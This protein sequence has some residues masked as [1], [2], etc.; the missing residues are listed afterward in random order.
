M[1]Y[2]AFDPPSPTR[3]EGPRRS[4]PLHKLRERIRIIRMPARQR[5]T[6]LHDIAGSPQHAPF[7]ELPRHVIVRAENVEIAGVDARDHEVDGLL[8]R[9]GAGRL[10][11]AA[12]RGQRGEDV[13][14]DHQMR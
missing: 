8:G 7:V 5:G 12:A 2:R 11:G 1:R 3:G 13:T 6:V 9:P 10:L 4:F 14:G